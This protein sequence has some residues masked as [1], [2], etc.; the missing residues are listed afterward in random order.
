MKYLDAYRDPHAAR[1]LLAR[2]RRDATRPWVVLEVCGGQ[3][4]NLLR[5]GADRDLPEGLELVH[6][7]GCPV[8]ATPPAFV[9]RALELAARPGVIVGAP[10]DLLRVPGSRGRDTLEAARRRGADVRDV[11]SPLDALA[12]ARNHPERPVVGL[13]VGFETT[14]PTA[15]AAVLEADRL[16]LENLTF[17]TSFF[18]LPPA[19]QAL[20]AAPDNR[21]RAVLASGPSAAVTGLGPFAPLAGKFGVP[22]VVIGPEP[23]DLLDGIARAVGQLERGDAVVEN[24]YARAV[25]PEGNPQALATIAAV[26]EPSDVR[27]RGLGVVAASGLRLR[28]RFR[29]FD[30]AAAPT[31]PPAAAPECREADVI[32][33]RLKP[34]SC[35]AFGI[36]CTP[37]HPLGAAMAAAEGTCAAYYRFRRPAAPTPD[38]PTVAAVPAPACRGR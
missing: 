22:V 21:A 28:P 33:G 8:S 6:G 19:V 9:D 2:I 7:P 35:P 23:V 13:A 29:R 11:Y 26:F 34:T 30:A 25:R 14:A 27:W 31:E 12:L 17:L 38:A 1:D 16:G 18:R 24:Q 36:P 15:A 4:R 3:A 5:F 37:D 32:A 10:G 20:L